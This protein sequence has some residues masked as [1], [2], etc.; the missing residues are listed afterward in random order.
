MSPTLQGGFLTT[1]SPGKFPCPRSLF[2]FSG[3]KNLCHALLERTFFHL[4]GKL[5]L[6]IVGLYFLYPAFSISLLQ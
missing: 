6:Y 5:L 4:S 1:G 2:A 3:I